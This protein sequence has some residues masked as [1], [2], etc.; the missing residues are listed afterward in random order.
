MC[1]HKGAN[2]GKRILAL[3]ISLSCTTI[4]YL[5]WKLFQRIMHFIMQKGKNIINFFMPNSHSM[6]VL[7]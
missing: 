4:F 2:G 6:K 5:H 3:A 1:I 7:W